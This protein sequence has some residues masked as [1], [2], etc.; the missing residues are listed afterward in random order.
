MVKT[1]LIDLTCAT[2]CG[3]IYVC[4]P[5]RQSAHA[6]LSVQETVVCVCVSLADLAFA[7]LNRN[8]TYC[9]PVGPIPIHSSSLG[10]GGGG[11]ATTIC[12]AHSASKASSRWRQRCASAA[13]LRGLEAKRK[14]TLQLQ[15]RKKI[16][17]GRISFP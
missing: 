4:S 3:T 11:R 10:S 6:Q 2:A 5:L 12:N 9:T 1:I 14:A 13:N 15:G 16:P 7:C 8:W 17:V